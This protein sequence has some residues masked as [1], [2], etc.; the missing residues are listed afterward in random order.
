MNDTHFFDLSLK[1]S[2]YYYEVKERKRN[3][4]HYLTLEEEERRVEAL[5]RP[6]R[7]EGEGGRDADE[8]NIPGT[9]VYFFCLLGF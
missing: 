1:L 4:T 6:E 3:R 8:P 9:L 5:R 7:A 2:F